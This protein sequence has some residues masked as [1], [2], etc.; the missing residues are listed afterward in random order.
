[1][2]DLTPDQIRARGFDWPGPVEEGVIV[3]APSGA[4]DLAATRR[5]LERLL[6]FYQRE[7]DAM[8]AF[9][10]QHN[11]RWEDITDKREEYGFRRVELRESIEY[12]GAILTENPRRR[13]ESAAAE[14]VIMRT[15]PEEPYSLIDNLIDI[16]EERRVPSQAEVKAILETYFI[17]IIT[18]EIASKLTDY[19]ARVIADPPLHAGE[20]SK[21]HPGNG[22]RGFGR[23]WREQLAF[24]RS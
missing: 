17:G 15:A 2:D 14:S 19:V 21:F 6:E 5:Q 22:R 13:G 12:I 7:L 1:M 3:A 24:S 4:I 10:D 20:V 23:A 11:A 9:R 16:R 18:D 8:R